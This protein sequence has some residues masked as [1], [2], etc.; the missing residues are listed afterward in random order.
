MSI[1]DDRRA[2]VALV[3]LA[4]D[5]VIELKNRVRD[6]ANQPRGLRPAA[7]LLELD[8]ILQVLDSHSGF[9]SERL[10]GDT[11]LALLWRAEERATRHPRLAPVRSLSGYF[12]VWHGSGSA[13]RLRPLLQ[14]LRTLDEIADA[15]LEPL[16]VDAACDPVPAD[17]DPL[18]DGVLYSQGYL[19]GCH[20]HPSDDSG[21]NATASGV[22]GV[23]GGDGVN[24][25]VKFVD[26][27]SGW[28]L[29]HVEW[30]AHRELKVLNPPYE[31]NSD[32]LSHGTLSLGAVI[33]PRQGEGIAGIAPDCEVPG[34][35]AVGYTD[36]LGNR[37]ENVPKAI[38][39]AVLLNG[40]RLPLGPGDVLL[41][42]R[43]LVQKV[44]VE[45]TPAVFDTI[46]LVSALGVTVIEPAGNDGL[47][48]LGGGG[49]GGSDDSGAIMVSGCCF[50]TVASHQHDFAKDMNHG[51]RVDVYAWWT[52]VL[53]TSYEDDFVVWSGTSAAASLIAGVAVVVHDMWRK[54]RTPPGAAR[55]TTLSPL[56]L[57]H[58]L[59]DPKNGVAVMNGTDRIG[60]M[61]DLALIASTLGS[62]PDVYCRD[63][64]TDDGT[65]PSTP[66][67]QSPDVF[68]KS[69]KA[70]DR[71]A[72]YG[73]GSGT[74]DSMVP[75]DKITAGE[76][77]YV[78]VRA[79]N[80]GSVQATGV[81]ARAYWGDSATLVT[82]TS[83][84][85]I[86][87]SDA[88]DVPPHHELVVAEPI[89]WT[90]TADKLPSTGHG[91]FVVMLHHEFDPAPVP[92]P[93]TNPVTG[94]PV[95]FDTFLEFL[96]NNNN[97]TWRNFEVLEPEEPAVGDPPIDESAPPVGDEVEGAEDPFE[98][99]EEEEEVGEQA[100]DWQDPDGQCVCPE[101][102]EDD[103]ED[104]EDDGPVWGDGRWRNRF[105]EYRA[106][107]WARGASDDLAGFRFELG[108][109]LSE[110]SYVALEVPTE[111]ARALG[112]GSRSDL[113]RWVKGERVR[114]LMPS[115]E[116]YRFPRVELATRA[117]FACVLR[118]LIPKDEPAVGRI[119]VRQVYCDREVGRVTFE[120]AHPEDED[121]ED[122]R[123]GA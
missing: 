111:F 98:E 76:T 37:I 119:A 58:I 77:H 28:Q 34:V 13:R 5:S 84:H 42:E 36:E 96:A 40:D 64:V 123:L 53:S 31:N 18:L 80:A 4:P 74:E 38:V 63:S 12:R 116:V 82:P 66:V 122:P 62:I 72:E 73:E 29:D 99:P 107:F 33:A 108:H 10:L 21:V 109:N 30:R 85:F 11:D 39:D 43:Q 87:E 113:G 89:E 121:R 35:L 78:Y 92:F 88:F 24:Q 81:R 14:D 70:A 105:R 1:L 75:N 22:W 93:D 41:I 67:S 102:D 27:E 23:Y 3:R 79:L 44:P 114:L 32:S 25:P 61:P 94:L 19:R 83:W 71:V 6:G 48:D 104:E 52:N 47:A 68:I 7:E 100:P 15:F 54:T 106:R 45:Y 17:A 8:E 112:R 49:P 65:M 2:R 115:A 69:V 57:R 110:G 55:D 20:D 9:R 56:Q 46:R 59:S 16:T 117:A 97:V 51:P 95:D 103:D 101:D 90:P 91:C 118:I 26:L 120:L 86:G 60:T 50:K